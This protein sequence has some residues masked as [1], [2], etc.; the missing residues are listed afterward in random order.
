ML[1]DKELWF[2]LCNING[3]G[4]KKIKA[5]IE[6]YETPEEI[7]HASET[8]LSEISCLQKRDMEYLSE[9]HDDD[10][11]AS[12]YDKILKAG[13]RF[14]IQSDK[15][16][17]KRLKNLYD[18]PYGLYLKGELPKEEFPLVAIIGARDC[19][20][21]G[22]ESAIFFA[23][24][25]ASHGISI[26]SGLAKG[27]DG[28]SH[29]GAM[30]GAGYTLGILGSGINVCYPQ[31]NYTLYERMGREGGILSE[32]GWN[33]KPIAG[34]FPRRNR[35]I[36][37]MSDAILVVEARQRS[38]SLITVDQGLEQG[39]NIFVIPGRITDELSI[40]CNSLVRMGAELVCSPKDVLDFFHLSDQHNPRMISQQIIETAQMLEAKEREVYQQLSFEPVH[41]GSLLHETKF[42]VG[43]LAEIL[44]HLEMRKIIRQVE[45]NY[46][47]IRI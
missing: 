21:Y 8:T 7:Y 27:I 1:S 19:T 47:A 39:K 2:W 23:R 36:A 15:D 24:E 17:P 33:V 10:K 14:L 43:E 6:Y 20:N 13:I 22:K 11:I 30:E 45:K 3:I 29:I 26:V 32:Y 4:Y 44:F 28:Y 46:Y 34:N 25:L 37:G 42:E 35:L 5:L 40:G 38:G 16:Y 41:I 12:I 18:A 9:C 31:S